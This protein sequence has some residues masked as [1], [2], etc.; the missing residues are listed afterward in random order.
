MEV[1]LDAAIQQPKSAILNIAPVDEG[2]NPDLFWMGEAVY[3]F[4]IPDTKGDVGCLD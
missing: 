3:F 2:L 4:Y 1:E